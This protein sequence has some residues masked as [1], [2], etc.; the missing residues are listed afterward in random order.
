MKPTAIGTDL[1]PADPASCDREPIHILGSI[2]PFGF[3]VVV[4]TDWIVVRVSENV[5]E[6]LDQ[7]AEAL[8]G[9][10]LV[11]VFEGE[12]VHQIRGKLQSIRGPG[13]VERIFGLKLSKGGPG[14]DVALH[15][16]GESIVIE[17]EP[18]VA[19]STNP[20]DLVRT[21]VGRLQQTTGFGALCREAA[22]QMR[23]L[24]GF[25]RVMVYRF[26]HD[27]SGE[28]IAEAAR[29]GLEPYLG[30][31]YPA[32]DIP[33]Q[34][35]ALYER[36]WLRLIADV[37]AKPAA[38][39]PQVNPEGQPLDL[40]MSVLRSVSPTHLEYLRNMGVAASLSVSILRGGKLWGLFACHH[41]VPNHLSFERRSG[42]ELFGQM[43]SWIMEGRERE[44]DIAY[45]AHARDLHNRL[46]S[47]LAPD[48]TGFDGLKGFLDELRAIVQCDGIG[49]SV[50]GQ[51]TLKGSTPT[52]GEMVGVVRYLNQIASSRPFTTN[53]FGRLHEP[54]K[55]FTERAAGLLVIPI[56]R[57]P[58]DYLIFFRREVA[59]TVNW[60][61]NPHKAV[62][63]GPDGARLRPR[64]SFDA[65]REIVRGQSVPWSEADLRIAESLRVTLLEMMLRLTDTADK[66]RKGAQA[67]QELLIAELNHRV[68]NILNLIRALMTQ[69]RSEFETV[70]DF[71]RVVG[72]RIQALARAHDQITATNWGP[73][74]LHDLIHLEA[75]AY[76]GVKA[77]RV[78]IDGEDVLLEPQA[79]STMALVVHEMMTNSA[80]YGA[81]ADSHG[82]ITVELSR[83]DDELVLGWSEMG[84]PPVKA[85]TRRGF[86]TTIIERSIP[87]ELKGDAKIRYELTGVM[88]RFT[89]PMRFVSPAPERKILSIKGLEDC[90]AP[91]CAL[92]GMVLL[93]E[94]NIV[95][96]LEGEEML[97]QL[98]ADAV[99]MASSVKEALRIIEAR[100]PDFAVLD[101]NLGTETS[102]LV[103]ER[104]RALN[105]PFIFAT[106][107]GESFVIPPAL[108]AVT[109]VK[110]PFDVDAL[111][112][113]C[114]R[115]VP[116][117]HAPAL[118]A[119]SD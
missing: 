14:F 101:V 102:L 81:L 2:Q 28:V 58:R 88:A 107:Y 105:V 82:T 54:A 91:P 106:G 38:I 119:P 18:S 57:T 22:R 52:Q 85:P 116:V 64:T 60:A 90:P 76:L 87:Y 15:V 30:L 24:T 74:S 67:H 33:Q 62:T 10:H 53:E 13:Q 8:L 12:A 103:A 42:I 31:R 48:R 55:A 99:E 96:A 108:G 94:D 23:A 45:E 112:S 50:E 70:E 86:G 61:G 36:N 4:S 109:V 63:T 21:L 89:V 7:P 41:R 34:A 68:R 71:A 111:R 37:D 72:G 65:W 32:S 118:S 104:L 95:I 79:F 110:K 43:F 39:V 115:D 47:L 66:E 11:E 78:R 83:D 59:R 19:G 80:K 97:L 27:G 114:V 51:V 49:M 16:S 35:R 17:A 20:V 26:D 92:S 84:G 69:S 56:S 9:T 100:P 25:E 3:L 1:N 73:G 98:G 75:G 29:A 113:A 93:V 5:A 77:E 117:A 46:M 44:V 40:S 6:W